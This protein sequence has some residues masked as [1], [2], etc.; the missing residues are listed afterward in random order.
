MKLVK[1]AARLGMIALVT[2]VRSSD[3]GSPEAGELVREIRGAIQSS[4]ISKSWA[5]EKITILGESEVLAG[6]FSPT[7]AKNV[8]V[9]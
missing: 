5:I 8:V 6:D 1:L 9:P 4:A 2:L 3:E 7:P